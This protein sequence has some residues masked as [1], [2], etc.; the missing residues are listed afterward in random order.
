MPYWAPMHPGFEFEL[1]W[2]SGAEPTSQSP[3]VYQWGAIDNNLAAARPDNGG[4]NIV[5]TLDSAPSWAA[6]EASRAHQR[7]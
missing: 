1:S 4:L 2:A 5:A 3:P 6:P 7:G